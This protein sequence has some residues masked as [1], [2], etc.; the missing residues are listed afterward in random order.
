MRI[1]VVSQYFW[2]ENF[3]INDIVKGLIRRGH[4]V[5]VLTGKPNYPGGDYY[6]GYGFFKKQKESYSG[7]D[8]FRVP[9]IPRGNGSG[10]RLIV[11]YLSFVLSASLMG[12]FLC[13][14]R[15]DAIFV[16]EVS[17][18]TV[19]LPAIVLKKLKKAPMYFW[20]LDLWPE[21]LSSS[22]RMKSG[23]IMNLVELLVRF[24]YKHSDMILASSKGF[25]SRI[26]RQAASGSVINYFPN[27]IEEV[28][29]RNEEFTTGAYDFPQGFK[30]MFAGNIGYS[31]AFP[32]ILDAV[33]KLKNVKDIHW[34]ILGDGRMAKWVRERIE[35]KGLHANIHMA[36]QY[37]REYMPYFYSNVDALLVSLKKEPNFELTVPGKVQSYL[38]SGKPIIASLDGEGAL[39]IDE[40]VAGVSCPAEDSDALA[41]AVLKLYRMD[42]KE[43]NVLGKN[44]F[45]Y[46][47]KH[48][49]REC[50]LDQLENWLKSTQT[51][52]G[53]R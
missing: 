41:D 34:I 26:R 14:G 13:K 15:Y 37:P 16:F 46:C 20:V 36:G 30:I 24:I 18:V 32:T 12:P 2:P 39:L 48:F 8:V 49:D 5:T 22:G 31:Q 51:C 3:R 47:M 25:I 7:A 45:N 1:L 35:R 27:F 10:F 29:D 43:L 50:L 33:E 38:Y 23:Y 53:Q 21:S 28:S 4:D 52:E 9:L 42:K 40:A 44:G 6:E 17:P 11:N 19:G